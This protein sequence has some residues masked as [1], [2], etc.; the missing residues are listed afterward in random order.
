MRAEY[1]EAFIG[2][3]SAVVDNINLF[4]QCGQWRKIVAVDLIK[5][6]ATRNIVKV[7]TLQ[8]V[9]SRNPV[10]FSQTP[11]RDMTP[12]KT[13]YTRNENSFFAQLKHTIPDF[14][15]RT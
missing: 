10:P 15:I 3:S 2:C 7:A 9:T 11:V 5:R 12:Q 13:C 6:S 4:H 1:G 8:V 14:F